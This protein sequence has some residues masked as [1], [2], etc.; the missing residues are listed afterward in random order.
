M[1][2]T[3][4]PVKQ[5]SEQNNSGDLSSRESADMTFIDRM[6]DWKPLP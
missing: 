5:K 4:R 1:T 6:R 3:I 2:A